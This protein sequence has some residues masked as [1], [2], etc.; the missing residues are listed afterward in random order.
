MTVP[1]R[2]DEALERP[3]SHFE[4]VRDVRGRF[5][6]PHPGSPAAELTV[7]PVV[8]ETGLLEPAGLDP[9]VWEVTRVWGSQDKPP[10]RGHQARRHRK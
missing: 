4:P 2:I 5:T 8:D 1:S 10:F 3:V 7:A 9:T 6:S